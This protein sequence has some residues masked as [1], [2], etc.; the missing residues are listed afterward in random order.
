[1]VVIAESEMLGWRDFI[2]YWR[3]KNL[4][5]G[6]F[7]TRPYTGIILPS[8]SDACVEKDDGTFVKGASARSPSD[9]ELTGFF[10][11]A[12]RLWSFF[13]N[14]LEKMDAKKRKHIHTKTDR[15]LIRNIDCCSIV[16]FTDERKKKRMPFG[17]I[18][19]SRWGV[20]HTPCRHEIITICSQI[21]GLSVDLKTLN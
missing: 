6:A 4:L 3:P 7:F 17:A 14:A 5:A 9:V 13:A 8:G 11:S 21:K 15:V 10:W 19:L 2:S 12:A 1:M 18:K 16:I 20:R